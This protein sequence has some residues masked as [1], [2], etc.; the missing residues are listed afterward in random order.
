MFTEKNYLVKKIKTKKKSTESYFTEAAVTESMYC[1][2]FREK[3]Y[4]DSNRI[5]VLLTVN[6]QVNDKVIKVEPIILII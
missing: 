4:G 2:I 5:Q 6:V 1:W 3:S